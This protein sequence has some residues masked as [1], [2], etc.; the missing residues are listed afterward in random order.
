MKISF[1]YTVNLFD[2]H[3]AEDIKCVTMTQW[4]SDQRTLIVHGSSEIDD[5]HSFVS[6]VKV[7]TLGCLGCM[8]LRD[9]DNE[10]SDHLFKNYDLCMKCNLTIHT[11]YRFSES[12]QKFEP[13]IHLNAPDFIIMCENSL[14]HTIN[15]QLDM[16][17][18]KNHGS[19]VLNHKYLKRSSCDATSKVEVGQDQNNVVNNNKSPPDDAAPKKISIVEQILADFSEYDVECPSPAPS[20]AKLLVPDVMH[21]GCEKLKALSVESTS[22]SRV[23][24]SGRESSVGGSSLVKPPSP[25]SP[26]LLEAAAKTYEFS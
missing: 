4:S 2:D 25:Q 14:I 26:E 17:K 11:K 21:N 7:P 8:Q 20:T 12:T 18:T 5:Q 24:S 15:V 16:Q 10:T 3:G 9:A 23:T 1:Q 19:S 13:N 6:I 22:Q